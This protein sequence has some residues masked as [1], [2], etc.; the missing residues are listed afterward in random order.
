ML[1]NEN[2]A[3]RNIDRDSLLLVH[4]QA[5]H[6]TPI[7]RFVTL[8]RFQIYFLKVY[9]IASFSKLHAPWK[10]FLKNLV[11]FALTEMQITLQIF[12]IIQ[13]QNILFK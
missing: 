2:G 4:I 11:Q 6:F 8:K 13:M 5:D 3:K 1:I 12:R 10:I 7:E 9:S